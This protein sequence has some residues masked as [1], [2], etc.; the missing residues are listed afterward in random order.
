MQSTNCQSASQPASQSATNNHFVSR[1]PKTDHSAE[2][3][4]GTFWLRRKHYSII[5][6]IHLYQ[7]FDTIRFVP[8]P[9]RSITRKENNKRKTLKS[10]KPVQV[11]IRVA[12]AQ[13]EEFRNY[14]SKTF[15]YSRAASRKLETNFCKFTNSSRLLLIST[16]DI[17]CMGA[18]IW[19]FFNRSEEREYLLVQLRMNLRVWIGWTLYF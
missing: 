2:R 15:L 3:R 11:R 4:D 18:L 5:I 13:W 8:K 16:F 7:H 19:Y 12:V 1:Q 9:I 17:S 10:F 6:I 14:Q